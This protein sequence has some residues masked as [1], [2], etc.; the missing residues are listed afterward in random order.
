MEVRLMAKDWNVTR[1]QF[2][3]G[4]GTIG[5]IAAMP[6]LGRKLGEVFEDPFEGTPVHGVGSAGDEIPANRVIYTTCE[7]CN[8][9]CTIKVAVTDPAKTGGVAYARKIAGNPY[10]PLNTVPFGQIDYATDPVKAVEGL[11]NLP[12]LGRSLRGGR[13]CLKGQA[14]IQT[15]YDAYRIAKPLK[16]VGPRGSGKWQTVEWEQALAEIGAAIKPALA[17]TPQGPV[18]TDWAKVKAGELTQA[19]FDAKYQSVLIDTKHPDLGPKVNQIAFLNGDRAEFM[20]RMVRSSFGCIN[21]FDHGGICG[22][23]GVIANVRTRNGDQKKKRQYADIDACEYLIAW[24]TNPMTANK[25]PTWLAPKLTNA[26]ERGMKLVVVDPRLSKSA[27]KAH[28]WV[29][30]KPGQDIALAFGM[31]RW[32]IENKRYD[33]R[34]LTNPNPQA[35]KADGE[36]TWSDATHLVNSCAT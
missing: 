21:F 27:E 14:G 29:P 3:I 1:R 12:E 16:R 11:G 23:T 30:I 8:T 22:S 2:V 34:Y 19:E 15:A 18:M 7:Q 33:A 25:G 36:P 20:D 9:F 5:S 24:G 17:F 26:M 31:I 32:I 28:L 10:S 6:L 4:A 35:A 13:T